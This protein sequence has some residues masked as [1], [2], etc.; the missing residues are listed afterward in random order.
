MSS[1]VFTSALGRIA[2]FAM[3]VRDT[4]VTTTSPTLLVVPIETTGIESDTNMRQRDTLADILA[5][6]TNEQTTA[7]RKAINSGITVTVDETAFTQTCKA[8]DVTWSGANSAGNQVTAF[9]WCYLPDRS[10]TNDALAIPLTK[11]DR[12]WA[13]DGQPFILSGPN[14]FYQGQAA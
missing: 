5:Q 7:G 13:P 4:A 14:G 8:P 2:S 6:S 3:L 9:I 12:L 11:H 10:S 1:F